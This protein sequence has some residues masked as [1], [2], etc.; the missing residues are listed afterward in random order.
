[1]HLSAAADD[2]NLTPANNVSGIGL[3]FPCD[4][5]AADGNYASNLTDPRVDSNWG[6]GAGIRPVLF[7]GASSYEALEA[8]IKKQM[9]HGVQGQF[10]YT[11]SHCNDL[12]SAPVTC[13][14]FLNSI[15]VPL[16]AYK[17]YRVGPC[18]FDLRQVA[19]GNVI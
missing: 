19:T 18:D 13:D 2:I 10:S 6:G 11:Y 14:T 16:L 4:P 7:D 17:S 9:S 8:Q 12:S 5:V 15:A 3:V 1:M